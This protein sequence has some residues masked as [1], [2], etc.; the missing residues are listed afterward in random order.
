MK[1]RIRKKLESAKQRE[2][3]LRGE[4]VDQEPFPTKDKPRS[5]P[6]GG[7]VFED[8]TREGAGFQIIGVSRPPKG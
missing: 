3:K 7:V 2:E 6:T 8:V 5:K 4:I 1:E